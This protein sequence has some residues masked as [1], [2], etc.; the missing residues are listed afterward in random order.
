[1]PVGAQRWQT[2]NSFDFTRQAPTPTHPVQDWTLAAGT[3]P[4]VSRRTLYINLSDPQGFVNR[5]EN[6]PVTETLD[7]N[8]PRDPTTYRVTIVLNK[9]ANEL[10]TPINLT[11]PYAPQA[12]DVFRFT[13]I[14][15]NNNPY[16]QYFGSPVPALVWGIDSAGGLSFGNFTGY[17]PQG[18]F[19]V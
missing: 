10:D 17:F 15:L 11:R 3:W 14:S 9:L 4:N 5:T 13:F 7:I 12:G 1:M 8:V 2:S 18:L 16:S 19:V 6:P